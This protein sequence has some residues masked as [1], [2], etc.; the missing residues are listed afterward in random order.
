MNEV[1][2]T[3]GTVRDLVRLFAAEVARVG[4]PFYG[5][6]L[7]LL[8]DDVVVGGPA[9]DLLAPL[10][11]R[12][13]DGYYPLRLLAAAHWLA[14]QG[15]APDIAAH[16][17]STGGDGDADAAWP[18]IRQMLADHPPELDRMIAGQIQTN[19]ASRAG[20]LIVGFL[21]VAARTG[22]PLRTL[23]VGASAG[24]NL[25][26]DRFRYETGGRG[27]GPPDAKVRFVDYWRGGTP[28]F[29]APLRVAERRGCDL[30]P[31]D[32]TDPAERTRL[33]SFVWP[34]QRHRFATIRD[35]IEI[36]AVDP[37][38]VD[39][40]PIPHWLE[41]QLAGPP[42]TGVATVVFH[43][44]AW[45]YL[46]ED[47]R[48]RAAA[49]IERAGA[50]ATPDAPV[51]WLRYEDVEVDARQP[52]LRLRLWPDGTDHLLGTGAYHHGPFTF[53]SG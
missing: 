29:D 21:E 31:I 3:T 33:L 6:L 45:V 35:A 8:A 28:A 16:F 50:Q 17:A 22:L 26:F 1:D 51:A 20:A 44:I 32:V 36:A 10:G 41:A 52:E 53:F 46:D 49:A 25:Q 19:E 14:L 39:R 48:R 9:R 11:A 23:E 38:P 7:G 40:A 30:H 47:D 27:F 42:P 24:L 43:S 15:K 13:V 2:D 12:V 34:D 37:A 4:S 18:P 5:R